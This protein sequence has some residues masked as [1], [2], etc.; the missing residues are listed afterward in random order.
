[1]LRTSLRNLVAYKVRLALTA[2]AVVFGV[3]F[4]AAV[5]VFGDTLKA[6]MTDAALREHRGISVDV[7]ATKH[8]VDHLQ[9]PPLSEALVGK[10]RALPGAASVTG[11]V[12]GFTAVVDRDGR[13]VG[14]K[15]KA[16]GANALPGPDGKDPRYTLTAGRLPAKAGEVALDTRTAKAAKYKVGDRIRI[17][18]RGPVLDRSVVG[19]FTTDSAAVEAGGS[20]TLLDTATAQEL[21]L[22]PGV[23]SELRLH[24]R[25]GTSQE[26]LRA[27]AAPLIPKGAE[28]LTGD[29][30]RRDD[31]NKVDKEIASLR[32]LL[33]V[34]AGIALFVGSFIIANTFSMLVAQRT[35]ELALLRAIG[36][37]RTQVTRSVM[38]EALAVGVVAGL[39]GFAIGIALA[40]GLRAILDTVGADLTPGP[41]VVA[42]TTALLSLAVGIGVT[43]LA[44]WLPVRRAAEIPPVAALRTNLPPTTSSLRR[45]GIAGAITMLLGGAV[46]LTGIK[47]SATGDTKVFTVM[48]GAGILLVGVIV[49]TPLVSGPVIRV[50][51]ALLGRVYP[52]EGRLAYRNAARNPRR[53]AATAA[54]LMIGMVLVTSLT[55]FSTSLKHLVDRTLSKGIT[56]E[57][58]LS[59]S[60]E[61]QALAPEIAATVAKVPGVTAVSPVRTA[62]ATVDGKE[63]DLTAVD[64]AS[65]FS[66]L[67]TTFTQGG[68]QSLPTGLLVSKQTADDRAWRVGTSV[69]VTFPDGQRTH[70]PIGGIYDR[71]PLLGALTVSLGTLAPHID[72]VGDDFLLAKVAPRHGDG[73]R[74][75]LRKA[76]G[77]SPAINVQTSKEV[78]KDF[79]KLFDIMLDIVYGLLSMAIVI[80]VLGVVNTLAMSVFERTREIG[81]MRAIGLDRRRTRRVIRLESLIISLFGGLLGVVL[82]LIAGVGG[83][84]GMA[85]STKDLTVVI[86]WDRVLIFLILA[87]IVGVL[88]AAWPARRAAKLDVLTALRTD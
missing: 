77:N 15:S 71:A 26:Q 42:P 37:T 9:T 29:A 50:F 66:V 59:S 86:P 2:L 36:A 64:P 28:A 48:G 17:V 38:C 24:A 6:A 22:E 60:A 82:G 35:R 81:M 34:F 25:P 21:Y 61:G 72:V 13:L 19:V 63:F 52:V 4:V 74:D 11:H 27:A 3:A 65:A 62:R 73:M 32:T 30:L 31:R 69:A 58:V 84:K 56:A 8:S 83:T 87:A 47:G 16:T 76:V 49:L 85:R 45:R 46:L 14:K 7:R 20:L 70:L 68:P 57:F 88:A 54:A 44:A 79:N 67:A 10:L 78:R 41:T 80:A 33:L 75:A 23:Y 51:G 39:G 53:T 40:V 18:A 12:T 55:V 1:M 43:L 5:L